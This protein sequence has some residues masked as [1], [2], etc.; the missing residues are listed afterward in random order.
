M[1]RAAVKR[2][3]PL[4][5]RLSELS[6]AVRSLLPPTKRSHQA[7]WFYQ[8]WMITP[9]TASSLTSRHRHLQVEKQRQKGG[10]TKKS[11]RDVLTGPWL[12]WRDPITPLP[13]LVTHSSHHRGAHCQEK[14]GAVWVSDGCCV[15]PPLLWFC[16][17]IP[18]TGAPQKWKERVM[19]RI[20]SKCLEQLWFQ[21]KE[22]KP[23]QVN[24]LRIQPQILINRGSLSLRVFYLLC[25]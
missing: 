21:L 11:G 13:R 22:Q 1:M 24:R 5:T 12:W 4:N 18:L 7:V 3:T 17:L 10:F 2:N 8:C 9:I 6:A 14:S 15:I 25:W 16:R 23:V 20:R 19:R